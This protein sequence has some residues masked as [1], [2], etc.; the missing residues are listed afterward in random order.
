MQ[1]FTFLLKEPQLKI[2][3]L[4]LL[5]HLVQTFEMN[6]TTVLLSLQ[7]RSYVPNNF[8]APNSY[9][10]PAAENLKFV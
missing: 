8:D 9:A 3:H 6:H 4:Y 5:M 1:V 7:Q 10:Y 2:Q